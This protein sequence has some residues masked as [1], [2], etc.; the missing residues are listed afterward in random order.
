MQGGHAFAVGIKGDLGDARQLFVQVALQIAGVFGRESQRDLRRITHGL[1]LVVP[2]RI[3][4]QGQ[5]VEQCLPDRSM[6]GI[7]VVVPGQLAIGIQLLDVHFIQ[8]ERAGLVGADVGHRAEGFHCRQPADQGIFFHHLRGAQGEGDGDDRRQGLRYR[9]HRQTDGG[10][11]HADY[12]L[13]AQHADHKHEHAQRDDRQRDDATEA[14]EAALQRGADVFGRVQQ[15]CDFTKLGAATG[16]HHHGETAA[17]G[18]QRALISHVEPVAHGQVRRVQGAGVLGYRQGLPRQR[19]FLSHDVGAGDKAQVG[20]HD[21]A[22]FQVHDIA[23][24]Q[25]GRGDADELTVAR[26]ACG[27]SGHHAEG[28]DGALRAEFLYETDERVEDDDGQNDVTVGDVADEPGD[29]GG[30]DEHQ[31]HEVGEL[32]QQHARRA[33]LPALRHDVAAVAR[34][35]LLHLI[36]AQTGFCIRFQPSQGFFRREQIPQRQFFGRGWLRA[37]HRGCSLLKIGRV[38]RLRL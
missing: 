36:S 18:D 16:R 2:D 28:G 31:D 30:G 20:G 27:R 1:T 19:G 29:S 26:D 10:Q 24:H 4:A 34:A 11:Q 22:G 21:V 6:M 15:Q 14:R 37:G 12:R 38:N 8:R 32:I 33:A 25:L 35:A 3:I 23:G 7:G 13:A 17:V 9:R 5:G